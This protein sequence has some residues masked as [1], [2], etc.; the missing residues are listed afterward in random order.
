MSPAPIALRKPAPTTFRLSEEILVALRQ[1]ID[2]SYY[3]RPEAIEVIARAILCSH[4][5]YL[6]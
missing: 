6:S 5:I 1:R 3:D 4:C 2:S